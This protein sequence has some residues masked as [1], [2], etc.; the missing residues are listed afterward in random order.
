MT[1][2]ADAADITL[3]EEVRAVFRDAE[4]PLNSKEVRDRCVS[5]AALTEIGTV[6]WNLRKKGELVRDADKRYTAVHGVLRGTTRRRQTAASVSENEPVPPPAA[7]G[8]DPLAAAVEDIAPA[9]ATD[10]EKLRELLD[11]NARQA[12]EALDEY[13]WL[14]GDSEILRFLMQQR[15][16]ARNARDAVTAL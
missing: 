13:V 10:R 12:Q 7:P 6:L 14:V 11:R 4:R 16:A 1:A 3:T 9:P 5:R 2:N 15:D 8:V